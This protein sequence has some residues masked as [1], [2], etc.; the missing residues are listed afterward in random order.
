MIMLQQYGGFICVEN[1][2]ALVRCERATCRLERLITRP[3][4]TL[5]HH[6]ILFHEEPNIT[7]AM[8]S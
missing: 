7:K 5:V 6:P 2:I 8:E 4:I 1:I 3:E